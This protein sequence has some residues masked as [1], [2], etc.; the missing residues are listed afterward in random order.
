MDEATREGLYLIQNE[1]VWVHEI[2]QG[3]QGLP[4]IACIVAFTRNT[5]KVA[6][7]SKVVTSQKFRRRGCAERLVNR[8]CKL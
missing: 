2:Q 7:I 1:L 6:T 8:V 5:E 3:D 4:E